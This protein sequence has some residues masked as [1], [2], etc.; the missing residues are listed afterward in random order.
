MAILLNITITNAGPDLGPYNIFFIN[1]SNV[2]T[3]GPTNISKAVLQAGYVVSAPDGTVTV[4]VRSVNQP[5]VNYP[6]NLQVPGITTTTTTVSPTTTTSTTVAPT[7]TTTTA[8]P[9]LEELIIKA[10]DVERFSFSYLTT[11]VDLE[12]DFGPNSVIALAGT[13]DWLPTPIVNDYV[14]P[15]TG[16]IIIRAS[17]LSGITRMEIVANDA[18]NYILPQATGT[19]GTPSDFTIYIEGS[20]LAKLDGLDRLVISNPA[21]LISNATTSQLAK[22]L[23][24]ISITYADVSGS[25]ADL[26]DA[27][28]VAKTAYISLGAFNTVTGDLS[29]MPVSYNR[30][31]ISGANTISGNVSSIQTQVTV[32]NVL[33][34][35]TLTGSISTIPNINTGGLTQFNVQG[36]NTLS[37]HIRSFNIEQMLVLSIAGEENP[38]TPGIG[39]N[40]VFGDIDPSVGDPRLWNTGLV[41]FQVLGKNTITGT[42]S[43]F[44][45][46][47]ALTRIAIDGFNTIGG[48]LSTLPVGAPLDRLILNGSTIVAG[49]LSDL[50]SFTVLRT[51][52]FAGNN[53]VSGD[54]SDLPKSIYNFNVEGDATVNAYSTQKEK[55]NPMNRM[56][57]FPTNVAVNRLSSGEIEQL[58]IDLDQLVDTVGSRI[59]NKFEGVTPPS[60]ILYGQWSAPSAP[61][62]A[63]YNS[64]V[65]KLTAQG[66]TITINDIP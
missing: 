7:T 41:L 63:A 43:T 61:A 18:N 15:Y 9:V 57:V 22:T 53:T 28:P 50:T 31:N 42:L 38:A 21:V 58:V 6:L 52:S 60:I 12:I 34:A 59:W 25:I 48:D 5:C 10:T 54:L 46:C 20:E 16:D 36:Y 1:G 35:N 8:S 11:T 13:Y 40:T 3:P 47:T 23:T 56:A 24:F 37:G 64:L 66:G 30:I 4:R 17:D 45:N 32:F 2:I 51:V 65:V 19:A 29:T 14:T 33:G 55:A 26:P 44:Q 39:G 62:L 27:S 49:D